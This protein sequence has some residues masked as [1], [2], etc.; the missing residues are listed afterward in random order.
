MIRRHRTLLLIA[1]AVVLAAL[2]A[3]LLGGADEHTGRLDPENAAP[4]G[5]RAVARVLAANGVQVDTARGAD[6]LEDQEL[7]ADTTVLVTSAEN[8]G[9]STV[10]RLRD[11]VPGARLIVVE[12]PNLVLDEMDD[13][14]QASQAAA[15][16]VAAE[17]SNQSIRGLELAV[18]EATAFEGAPRGCFATADGQ[19]LAVTRE[20]ITLLGA[21]QALSNDQV[22]R[23]DNAALAL[24]LLG[25][26]DR[27]VWYVPDVA[28]QQAGDSVGL[29][30]LIPRWIGPALWL[31]LLALV[32]VM[33]WRGRRLGPL[34]TEPLPVTVQ[35]IESTH[36][37]GQ[38][39]RRAGAR[40]HAATVLRQATA[41]RLARR[42]SLPPSSPR[43]QL[44]TAVASATG[45]DLAEVRSLLATDAPDPRTDRDLTRLA[46]DLATLEEQAEDHP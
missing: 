3:T 35:S 4:E 39:Y 25:Q 5:A 16:D 19:L 10:R 38:L 40:G 43:D 33:V 28:D 30:S 45:R 1:L 15:D 29:Q 18:D 27:L 24:R 46:Q 9:A 13:R 17:C 41:E 12:P 23:A 36:G 34:V 6:E 21:G 44:A 2:A 31:G 42:L 37:R 26:R 22:T 11:A 7:G 14:V 32:L 8:L 20:G